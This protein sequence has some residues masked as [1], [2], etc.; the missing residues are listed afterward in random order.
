[1]RVNVIVADNTEELLHE[2]SDSCR[3][4]IVSAESHW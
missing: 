2:Y 3:I 4:P 1:M